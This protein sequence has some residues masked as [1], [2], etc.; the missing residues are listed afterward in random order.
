MPLR[1]SRSL[2]GFD[3][4]LWILFGGRVIAATGFSI[5]MPFLSIFLYTEMGVPMTLVGMIFLGNALSGAVGQIIGGEL[6]DRL[7]RRP[8]MWTSMALRAAVFLLLSLAI[9]NLVDLWLISVLLMVSSLAGSLF[10][11]ATNA[12]VAD[13][14][15]PGRRLEAYSILRVGQNVGW[16]LGPLLGGILAMF[17]YASLFV[18]TALTSA[19]VAIIM[20]AWMLDPRRWDAQ[21]DR[22]H[23][24]DLLKIGENRVF[25]LLC[26][27]T[28]PLMLVLGQMTSTFALFAEDEVG[29]SVA[30][31]GYLY[32]LNGVM[33]V[34][35]QLPM[36]RYVNR[37]R[38]THVL[39][40]GAVMYAAGYLIVG[41]ASGIWV[42]A[43]SMI[44]TTLG[45][46]V[47]SPPSINLVA[48]ISPENER[49]RYMG[50]SGIFQTFGW[51][52]GPLVGGV[53]YDTLVTTPM[54]LWGSIAAI[55]LLSAAGFM[56][57]SKIIPRETDLVS[58][59]PASRVGPS[60]Q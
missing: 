28:I 38:M 47:T 46:N 33:V 42:L 34:F 30:E 52:V 53:L 8:V 3:R 48:N 31:V 37:F 59:G 19:T 21:T 1:L 36:A 41:W 50:V 43:V 7:G 49:G 14:V 20:Y 11:P 54:V 25:L 9:A 57:L 5:V 45:E 17:S 2:Q 10:E 35:L 44:I 60:A 4:R 23:P 15:P 16:T 13:L 58:E 29:I 51:S 27:A 55:S 40:A 24:R 22:F 39:T 6:A 18:F 56:W 12:M 26:L 32:A